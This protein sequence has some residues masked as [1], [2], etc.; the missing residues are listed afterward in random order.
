MTTC[1][2]SEPVIAN[3]QAMDFQ[4]H[5][6]NYSTYFLWSKRFSR[7]NTQQH[8]KSTLHAK[9]FSSLLA[10]ML[11]MVKTLLQG[12]LCILCVL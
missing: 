9:I 2:F 6:K 5:A 8:I 4:H 1:L 10:A 3:H 11:A 12:F 7:T